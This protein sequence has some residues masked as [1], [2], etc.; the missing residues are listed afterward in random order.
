MFGYLNFTG[1]QTLGGTGTVVFGQYSPNTLQVS[2]A[3]T[4]LTI[5]SGITVRGQSGG[6]GYN[7]SL[8]ARPTSRW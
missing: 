1:S 7:P 8:G 4:T 2:E 5:G 6:V 3:S